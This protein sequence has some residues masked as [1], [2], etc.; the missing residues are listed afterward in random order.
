MTVREILAENDLVAL[1]EFAAGD[2]ELLDNGSDGAFD[3]DRDQREQLISF[4][5]GHAVVVDQITGELVGDV[6]WHPVSYGPSYA[7]T[8]WNFGIALLPS[9]RGRGLGVAAQRLLVEH[10]FASTDLD[11][12][13]ASTDVENRAEQRALEK[14]GLRREGVLRGAQLR[15]G[16]RRDIVVYGMVRS[17]LPSS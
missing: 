6:S 15:D 8:A 5:A 17:D 12:V 10:L 7:C 9:A 2:K 13:E 1:A 11:R 14:A 4:E 3:V 16:A